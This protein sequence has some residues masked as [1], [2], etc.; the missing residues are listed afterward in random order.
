[1]RG[2]NFLAQSYAFK[3]TGVSLTMIGIILVFLLLLRANRCFAFEPRFY[4]RVP[5]PDPLRT[6]IFSVLN[7]ADRTIKCIGIDEID[8]G[9]GEVNKNGRSPIYFR[10]AQVHEFLKEQRGKD[11]LVIWFLKPIMLMETPDRDDILEKFKAFSA[12]L[13]YKRVLIVGAAASGIYVVYDT[14][15]TSNNKSATDNPRQ[16]QD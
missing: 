5:T 12:D 14:E 2:K 11:L 8:V 3:I 7:K 15:S 6:E 1:M 9:I 16:N 4:G 13:G 10:R